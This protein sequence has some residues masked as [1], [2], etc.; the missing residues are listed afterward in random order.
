MTDTKEGALIQAQEK[1]KVQQLL[2][3]L[4]DRDWQIQELTDQNEMLKKAIKV[5]TEKAKDLKAEKAEE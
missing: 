1:I 2:E 4:A 3:D 5:T